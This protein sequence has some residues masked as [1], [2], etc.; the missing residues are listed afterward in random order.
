M[1]QLFF[2]LASSYAFLCFSS[3]SA[4]P[5]IQKCK[6][7]DSIC[8][9]KSTQ[10]AI[11]VFAK[12]LPELGVETMDPLI[13]KH[14]DASSPSLKLLVNDVTVTGLKNC[15]T[16]KMQRDTARSWLTVKIQCTAQLEGDYEMKGNLL[17]L[18][19][20]GKG[21]V[22]VAIRKVLIN[23]EGE[24]GEKNKSGGK[25]W[26]IKSWKSNFELKDKSDL[27]FENLFNGNEVLGRAAGELIRSSANDIIYEIGPTVVNGIITKIVD[28]IQQ[29]FSQVPVNDLALDLFEVNMA[30][31]TFLFTV[32][33]FVCS[34]HTDVPFIT[35]CVSTDASCLKTSAQ[36]AIPIF[37]SGVPEMNIDPLDPLY[38][39]RVESITDQ[40][41]FT[42]TDGVITG[43]GKCVV[44]N[45]ERDTQATKII[46]GAV[47]DL[48]YKGKYEVKGQVLIVPFEGKGDISA[49]LRK[50]YINVDSL[51]TV[52]TDKQGRKHWYI[53]SYEY[54]YEL[55][56]KTD[57]QLTKLF[58]G[59]EVL[60]RA[61]RE[62]LSSSGNE[63]FMEV[64][65]P[66]LKGIV[67]KLIKIINK[68]YHSIDANDLAVDP[69]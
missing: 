41:T 9:K 58:D 26:F 21:K 46:F 49:K 56:G 42:S 13:I 63:I 50:L 37:A 69:F 68:F 62:L 30:I 64:G 33:L 5:F 43:L 39:N 51:L 11:P 31:G 55:R 14:I 60:G 66:I 6:A 25:Y 16:K 7:E 8:I 57:I 20:E 19:I 59:N 12:G 23:I 61:A 54:N 28:N 4:V 15:V 34:V 47:C 10:D 38:I 65:P 18:P 53:K 22:H 52:K 27:E 48:D 44:E 35:K 40:L 67:D 2:L 3:A 24:L 45:V 36:A 1:L 29:F 32:F 17:I